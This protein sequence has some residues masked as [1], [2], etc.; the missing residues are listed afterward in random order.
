MLLFIDS[1]NKYL[2]STSYAVQSVVINTLPQVQVASFSFSFH[3]MVTFFLTCPCYFIVLETNSVTLNCFW[4][5]C[6]LF[7]SS[8]CGCFLQCLEH[9]WPHSPPQ[10]CHLSPENPYS[11]LRTQLRIIYSKSWWGAS[12][13]CSKSIFRCRP[14]QHITWI[15]ILCLF[16]SSLGYKL[17]ELRN[18]V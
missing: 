13:P 15:A 12:L 9:L 8:L 7:P 10:L 2:L 5:S 11:S 16:E 4:F 17:H 14:S 1:F 6:I 3:G 18:R